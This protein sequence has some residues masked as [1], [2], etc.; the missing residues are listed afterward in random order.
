MSLSGFL[1]GQASRVQSAPM[2]SRFG[3]RVAE[4]VPLA[5]RGKQGAAAAGQA[6]A[7]RDLGCGG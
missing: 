6:A 3:S 1:A 2:G 5:G 7:G 4:Y